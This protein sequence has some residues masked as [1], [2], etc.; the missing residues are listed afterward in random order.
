MSRARNFCFTLNNYTEG[1][2]TEIKNWDVKYLVF[3]KEVGDSGTPHLQGY[4]CFVNAKSLTSLKKL[5]RSAHWE[6]SRGTP[7][8]ASDYCKKDED[9]FEKGDLP[10][11]QIEKGVSEQIR[12][13]EIIQL[14]EV[15]DWDVLK[16]KYPVEYGTKLKNLEHINKKRKRDLSTI[17]GDMEHEWIYGPTGCGK[18]RSARDRFP[19]AYVKDPTSMWWDGYNG[20]E[21]VIIDDF[22]KFQVKQGGDMK[23]WLDR[24]AFQAQYKGGME[25]IRPRRIIVTSQ[26]APC[27]IWDDEKT[28]DAISRRVLIVL[29]PPL[30]AVAGGSAGRRGGQPNNSYPRLEP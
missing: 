12:W 7:R 27:E 26:Y 30:A 17:D 6:I 28:V 20:Q 21:T 9:F 22:D 23:R 29:H 16:E 10:L 4:V 15:G 13:R 1:E 5:S 14:S 3:G 24:Y 8:E 11:S 2:V 19:D 18:S 25:T